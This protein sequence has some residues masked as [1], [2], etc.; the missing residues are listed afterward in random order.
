MLRIP[1]TCTKRFQQMENTEQKLILKQNADATQCA[2][3][4]VLFQEHNAM[5]SLHVSSLNFS[6]MLDRNIESEM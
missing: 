4:V 3:I 5:M 6:E 1:G 2:I